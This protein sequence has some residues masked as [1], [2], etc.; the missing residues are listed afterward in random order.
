MNRMLIASLFLSG[1]VINGNKF[2]RPRDLEQAWEVNKPRL[3]GVASDPAE[4]QPGDNVTLRAL[5]ADPQGQIETTLWLACPP[6]DDGGIGFG[7]I[8]DEPQV[9][10]IE[11][12]SSPQFD[13]PDDLLDGMNEFERREGSYML[14]QVTGLPEL[15][16]AG[17]PDFENTDFNEIE[18]GYKR[19][20]VSEA[21]TPN[22]NPV[23]GA[24]SADG[25]EL[26]PNTVL[27]VDA[28]QEY[29]IGVFLDDDEIE[30]FEFLNS[31]GVVETR[32]EEPYVTWYATDGVVTE[33]FTLHPFLQSTWR[34]PEDAES[35]LEGII[36]AVVRDRRGGQDWVQLR[37]RVR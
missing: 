10:G 20:V 26:P 27:E 31:S 32:I 8:A 16:L 7:C 14:V 6:F 1:C 30:V 4:A 23:L 12:I 5:L 36:Y 11:P 18:A 15:D 19:V 33:P 13:V 21:T 35:G 28:G 3:L 9:I 34:A 22:H 2:K 37:F 17:E 24:L 29:D 25:E